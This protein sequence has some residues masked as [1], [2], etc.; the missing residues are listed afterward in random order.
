[1]LDQSSLV[2]PTVLIAAQS[3]LGTILGVWNSSLN[4]ADKESS[5][6]YILK[7]KQTIKKIKINNL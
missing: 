2:H 6:A 7:G 1:M 3:V 4:K 5:L